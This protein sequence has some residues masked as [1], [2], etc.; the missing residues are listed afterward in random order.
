MD[1]VGRDEIVVGVGVGHEVLKREWEE[2]ALYSG[3]SST[4]SLAFAGKAAVEIEI[5]A[6]AGRG[7]VAW[8][9]VPWGDTF[10]GRVFGEWDADS[11]PAVVALDAGTAVVAAS[12]LGRH[13][14]GLVI[15]IEPVAAAVAVDEVRM[16]T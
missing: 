16:G 4:G 10:G 2:E 5:G 3:R 7:M 11:S 1:R 6:E 13:I 12:G 15:E 14:E 8:A 9:R